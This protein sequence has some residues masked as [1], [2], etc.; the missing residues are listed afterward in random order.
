MGAIPGKYSHR[1]ISNYSAQ[2]MTISRV[3]TWPSRQENKGTQRN[4]GVL[5]SLGIGLED[6]L[7]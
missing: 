6:F 4:V 1:F 7:V 2:D 5:P 3:Q